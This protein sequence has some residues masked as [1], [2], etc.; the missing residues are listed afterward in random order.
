MS[1]LDRSHRRA[2]VS[3]SETDQVLAPK[4]KKKQPTSRKPKAKYYTK[5]QRRVL[6]KGKK[7][8]AVEYTA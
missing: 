7:G 4:M 8:K 5:E 1:F 2:E 3:D 6:N